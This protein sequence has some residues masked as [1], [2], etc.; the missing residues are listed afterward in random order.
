[1]KKIIILMIF[2]LLMV[3]CGPSE[4]ETLVEKVSFK[5]HSL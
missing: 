4:S 1:M 5:I 2:L 3:N